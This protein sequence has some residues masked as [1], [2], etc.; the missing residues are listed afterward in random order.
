M[1]IVNLTPHPLTLLGADAEK[2][3]IASSGIARLAMSEHTLG[4]VDG[5][6]LALQERRG[7]TGL[8]APLP[9][10]IYVV[11]TL[12]A[13]AV[14]D[15]E[16]VVAPDTGPG[17]VRDEQGNIVAVRGFV[18]FASPQPSEPRVRRRPSAVSSCS[19]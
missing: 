7:V 13:Q 14:A 12:V 18:R 19:T 16:D 6:P 1:A 11:S 15:R 2:R 5:Y 3:I 17:A 4:H 10:V 8:P 9:G